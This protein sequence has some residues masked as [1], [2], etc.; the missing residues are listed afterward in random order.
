MGVA[1][2]LMDV[3]L[4]LMGETAPLIYQQWTPFLPLFAVSFSPE[5]QQCPGQQQHQQQ[6][7]VSI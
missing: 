1:L 4:A 3:T 2:A 6:R 7:N 5:H